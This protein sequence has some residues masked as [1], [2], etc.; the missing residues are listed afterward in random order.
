MKNLII[1][2][3]YPKCA[4]TYLQNILKNNNHIN[5][6]GK[7]MHSSEFK[8]KDDSSYDEYKN[9]DLTY[10]ID[11]LRNGNEEEFKENFD[12]IKKILINICDSNKVNF[13]SDES[14]TEYFK[15]Y[16]N[17]IKI[18]LNKIIL[19]HKFI[20][21]INIRFLI[22]HREKD[23]LF[24][25]Y[26]FQNSRSLLQI[27]KMYYFNFYLLKQLKNNKLFLK[28]YNH[29]D[30]DHIFKYLKK[31]DIDHLFLK[32]E[33]KDLNKNV[34]KLKYDNEIVVNLN[35]DIKRIINQTDRNNGIRM[36]HRKKLSKVFDYKNINFKDLKLNK[37]NYLFEIILANY[38]KD[39][40]TNQHKEFMK[41]IEGYNHDY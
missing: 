1:H 16:D 2:L 5:F 32:L 14:L 19:I 28:L 21:N 20:K 27:N 8:S 10:L 6:L 25:S 33:I 26:L 38:K 13:L 3:G 30:I 35:N 9:N 41:I 36:F 17:E 18:L 7:F 37:L 11:S 12:I 22:I 40:S 23:E 24:Q 15:I 31:N 39:F 29:F 4:S 34:I